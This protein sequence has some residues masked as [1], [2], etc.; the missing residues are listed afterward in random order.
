MSVVASLLRWTIAAA[1]DVAVGSRHE[2]GN[3]RNGAESV[4]T[5]PL[6][7]SVCILS[8][9]QYERN[10][11]GKEFFIIVNRLLTMIV[12][13]A[14]RAALDPVRALAPI[15]DDKLRPRCGHAGAFG[16][17]IPSRLLRF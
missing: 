11:S 13:L 8:P 14:P 3:H 6:Y 12:A 7:P 1:R 16:L 5:S 9:W 10:R 15:M 4:R 17:P 2:R